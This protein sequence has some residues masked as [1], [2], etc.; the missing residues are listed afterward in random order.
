MWLEVSF[1]FSFTVAPISSKCQ[2]PE[3]SGGV[4][5]EGR[6]ALVCSPELSS[7]RTIATSLSLKQLWS[8]K[9][10]ACSLPISE[11][12]RKSCWP[13]I[14]SSLACLAGHGI[15]NQKTRS[16]VGPKLPDSSGMMTAFSILGRKPRTSKVST[17]SRRNCAWL[18]SGRAEA[19]SPP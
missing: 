14:L 18:V 16:T 9:S 4:V 5:G 10:L 15:R 11:R 8:I 19:S 7:L 2:H 6:G 12:P 1:L 17:R 13:Q 3:Q